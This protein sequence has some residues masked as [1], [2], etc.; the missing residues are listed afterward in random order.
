MPELVE[1]SKCNADFER[2]GF[3]VMETSPFES[4]T[5][6]IL[7]RNAQTWHRRDYTPD[8][9]Q[10]QRD[11]G[12]WRPPCAEVRDNAGHQSIL[13]PYSAHFPQR[14]LEVRNEIQHQRMSDN[15]EAGVRKR[16][17]RGAGN[18]ELDVTGERLLTAIGDLRDGW[19]DRDHRARGAASVH[20]LGECAGAATDFEP[21][22]CARRRKPI[23]HN[24]TGRVTARTP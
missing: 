14:A 22:D 2:H 7:A 15:V 9:A 3:D 8:L 19:I 12:V 21:P 20:K 24:H 6:R 23:A 16:Q 11:A 1:V 17:S 18:A 5:Q 10:A 13:T 4:R